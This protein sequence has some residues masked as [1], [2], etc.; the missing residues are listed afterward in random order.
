MNFADRRREWWGRLRPASCR[1]KGWMRRRVGALCLSSSE[2]DHSW[3]YHQIP[4][5]SRCHKDKHKAPTLLRIHPLSL[6]DGGMC[7]TGLIVKIHQ[8]GGQACL[9]A[10]M[11]I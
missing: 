9:Y 8:D 6:Q 3:E 2:Y 7:I 5:A 11:R 4:E 1:D 10:S